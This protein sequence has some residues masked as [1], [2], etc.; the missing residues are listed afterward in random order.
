[1][2]CN[3]IR[4]PAQKRGLRWISHRTQSISAAETLLITSRMSAFSSGFEWQWRGSKPRSLQFQTISQDNQTSFGPFP[5]NIL[6]IP[7]QRSAYVSTNIGPCQTQF[8]NHRN[9]ARY[10]AQTEFA[11]SLRPSADFQTSLGYCNSTDAMYRLGPCSSN[12]VIP[13]LL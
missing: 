9:D 4:S 11:R 10:F 1:M 6:Y 7:R 8:G 13:L 5:N 12:V 2:T 3:K